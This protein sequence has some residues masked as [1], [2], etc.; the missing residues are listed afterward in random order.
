MEYFIRYKENTMDRLLKEAIDRQPE[1]WGDERTAWADQYQIVEVRHEDGSE[2]KY[3]F[4]HIR[5]AK[6]NELEVLLL[7]PEHT[8]VAAFYINDLLSVKVK[9]WKGRLKTLH[10]QKES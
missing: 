8:S 1:I 4:V 9:P 10:K 5:Y 7:F 6:L 2:L 3:K